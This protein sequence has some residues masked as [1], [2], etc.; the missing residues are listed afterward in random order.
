MGGLCSGS[1]LWHKETCDEKGRRSKFNDSHC[2]GL[3]GTGYPQIFRA[4]TILIQWIDSV[5]AC[6]IFLHFVRSVNFVRLRATRQTDNTNLTH[7]GTAELTDHR[8]RSIGGRFFMVRIR[9]SQNIAGILYQSMLEP[10]SR[11]DEWITPL[12]GESNRAERPFHRTIRTTGTA[13]ESIT[14]GQSFLCV[15]I[16][17]SIGVQPYGLNWDRQRA[18]RVLQCSI[19][20]NVIAA[21]RGVVCDDSNLEWVH[22]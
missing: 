10:A 3:I 11:T 17:Q 7:Q 6:E 9:H 21:L 8:K 18:G 4:Q 22:E 20:C 5:V 19:G 14:R 13:K 2:A 1:H 16:L 15:L 12:A